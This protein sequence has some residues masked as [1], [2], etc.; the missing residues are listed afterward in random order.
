MET[1][2][3]LWSTK[4]ALAPINKIPPEVL[5]LIPNFWETDDRDQDVITLTH[6]CRAWR[7]IFISR[8]SLWANF[9]CICVDKTR[10]YL[11]RSKSSPI[12][13]SLANFVG[14]SPCDPFLQILPHAIGRLRSLSVYATFK[15][16]QDI[17]AHLS[18]PAP[19]LED[20]QIDGH[21]A[22][23]SQPDNPV[24]ASTLFNGDLSSLRVL[25]LR[26]VRTELPWRNMV[27][28]TTFTL[29]RTLPGEISVGHFLD[30]FESAPRLREVRLHAATPTF[31]AQNGRLASL[32]CLKR[33][34]IIGGRPSL[35]LDHL[36]I[37]VG[38][39]LTIR[40]SLRSSLIE[41][42]L[43]KSLDNLRNLSGFTRICLNTSR[44]LTPVE[45]SGPN[46]RVAI[47]SANYAQAVLESLARFDTSKTERLEIGGN[48][49]FSRYTC[50]Q[51]LLPMR[52]LR[53]LTLS[54]CQSSRGFIAALRRGVGSS[55]LVACPELEE[56]VLAFHI[57]EGII[58]DGIDGPGIIKEVIGMAAARVLRGAKLKCVR[59]IDH[60]KDMQ[61]DS[62][63]LEKHVLRVEY[64]PDVGGIG[65]EEG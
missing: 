24:L 35:L 53:T 27:N 44:W 56:L 51:T 4:N 7:E 34:N 12:N 61:I 28:L 2:H 19:F 58:K 17:T 32:V 46:G 40:T 10:V 9:D 26:S 30:F 47:S 23:Y 13:V 54:H 43:P 36:L 48:V 1:P 39:E 59:I 3:L 60:D 15:S 8:A 38:A 22:L 49:S 11:E 62:F 31:G 14:L 33:M 50:Y 5:S 20:L 6:V 18:L 64:G 57:D 45:F 63:E 52:G 21:P 55:G 65:N 25:C 41:D 37:P 16:L 29:V 42:H